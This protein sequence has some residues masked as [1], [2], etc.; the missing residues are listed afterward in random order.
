MPGWMQGFAKSLAI[1]S[2]ET[3]VGGSLSTQV[4]PDP[5]EEGPYANRIQG[6]V[7]RIDSVKRRK[8]PLTFE[9]QGLTLKFHYV[10]R[11]IGGINTKAAML[12]II[13]NFLILTYGTGGFWGG[14]NRYRGGAP[15]YPWKRG[16]AAWYSGS[17]SKFADAIADSVSA[18]GD[19][20]SSM[21]DN[22]LKDPIGTLKS[23]AG[24]GLGAAVAYKIKGKAPL[25]AG[26]RALLTGEPTGPWHLIVGNPFNP[27]MMIGN[28]ICES[29]NFKFS[30]ELGPD[31]FPTEMTV[32]VKLGHAM[33]RDR[34]GVE[35]MF[36]KGSGRIY[37]IPDDWEKGWAGNKESK[38]D[39][40]TGDKNPYINKVMG[41]DKNN[42]TNSKNIS[43]NT[44]VDAII[45]TGTKSW[46][47]QLD[48]GTK[49]AQK[50]EM[51]YHKTGE[52]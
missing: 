42:L 16:M 19:R 8:A 2:G 17:P 25:L 52:Q 1:G 39:K 37:T 4:P 21:F 40:N 44:D 43:K 9:Q 47:S 45:S 28:L 13:A 11:S 18:I 3:G 34:Y 29:C 46:N 7:N 35:S 24:S 22:I 32:E 23:I 30:D 49:I 51:G 20:L 36:N 38:V 48:Q 5:Y 6:P 27:I 15:S 26:M 14:A 12:D 33:A 50:V 10:A 41:V 31:D